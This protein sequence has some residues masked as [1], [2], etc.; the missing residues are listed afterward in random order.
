MVALDASFEGNEFSLNTQL[1]PIAGLADANVVKSGRELV[2]AYLNLLSLVIEEVKVK[3]AVVILLRTND[4]ICVVSER[5]ELVFI[6]LSIFDVV[7]CDDVLEF[8]IVA[9][10]LL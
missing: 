4:W 1:F 7:E 9:N 6:G 10:D 8:E 5:N 2:I 3:F